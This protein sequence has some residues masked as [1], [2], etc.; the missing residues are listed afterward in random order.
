MT[1]DVTVLQSPEGRRA[2]ETFIMERMGYQ[3]MLGSDGNHYWTKDG[4]MVPEGWI[5]TGDGMV[6]LKK[7]AA[8]ERGIVVTSGVWEDGTAES[9]SEWQDP[10]GHVVS[11]SVVYGEEPAT[12]V[13]AVGNALRKLA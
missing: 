7:W 1:W 13:L 3:L 11:A 2:V 5:Y 6:H 4:H 12:A 10:S 9:V 8:V